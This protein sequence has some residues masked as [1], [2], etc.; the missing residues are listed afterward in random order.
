MLQ[1]AWFEARWICIWFWILTVGSSW[2]FGKAIYYLARAYH[3]HRYKMMPFAREQRDYHDELRNWC[4]NQGQDASKGDPDFEKW[5]EALYVAAADE[6]AETNLVKSEY[7]FRELGCSVLL[8]PGG[9]YS[10]SVFFS[11][12]RDAHS[13]PKD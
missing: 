9:G 8:D 10:C 4:A 11:P 3:G 5:I 1:S 7:L 6:N 13:H 12:L 2:Y